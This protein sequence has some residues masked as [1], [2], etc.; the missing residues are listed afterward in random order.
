MVT[1]HGVASGKPYY[2]GSQAART[3][4]FLPPPARL[5]GAKTTAWPV[6][7]VGPASAC[8][9]DEGN[10]HTCAGS[11]AR[12]LRVSVLA[13]PSIHEAIRQTKEGSLEQTQF[14][15]NETTAK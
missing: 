15:F 7:P 4:Q 13:A 9:V 8:L 1:R 11:Q 12:G 14:N 5:M 3:Y 2:P 6:C 10:G